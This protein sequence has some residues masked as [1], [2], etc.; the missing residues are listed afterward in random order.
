MLESCTLCFGMHPLPRSTQKSQVS[1]ESD[2]LGQG[3]CV[4]SIKSCRRD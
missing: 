1:I 3:T 4:V 2:R